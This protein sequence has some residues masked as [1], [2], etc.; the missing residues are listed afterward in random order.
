MCLPTVAAVPAK[1]SAKGA[2]PECGKA[3]MRKSRKSTDH[4]T[5]VMRTVPT[6]PTAFKPV[7]AILKRRGRVPRSSVIVPDV[8]AM[9]VRA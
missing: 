3:G 9:V 1:L 7:A 6:K 2:N 5:G 8:I 4:A